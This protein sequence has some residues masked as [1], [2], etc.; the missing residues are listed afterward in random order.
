MTSNID[1]GT[2]VI[3][4]QIMTTIK[5]RWQ[6]VI[7]NTE[8]YKHREVGHIGTVTAVFPVDNCVHVTHQEYLDGESREFITAYHIEELAPFNPPTLVE[9]TPLAKAITK[10][11]QITRE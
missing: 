6:D 8:T 11:V 5:A 10:F 2:Q 3:C 1:F 7:F 9:E 4:T